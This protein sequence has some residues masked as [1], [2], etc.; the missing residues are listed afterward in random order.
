MRKVRYTVAASLDGFI[1]GPRGEVDWIVHNPE[2]DFSALYAQFD[3]VLIGRVTYDWML[4]HGE[5]W[6]PKMETYVFS[7]SLRQQDHP[8]VIISPDVVA[9]TTEL[10]SKEGKDIWIFGGG[11]LFRELLQA[12]LVDTVEVALMPA[13][14][15][16]GIPL[17]PP[18][19]RSTKLQITRQSADKSGI[20]S[21]DYAVVYEA[22][23][24]N[25]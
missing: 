15:G 14:L 17:L 23:N 24:A 25:P 2:F 22:A 4:A 18:P 11:I 6:M 3:T 13:I 10:R 20:V 21:L 7:R 5:Q 8:K 12:K 1:A 19:Y 16:D 9:A